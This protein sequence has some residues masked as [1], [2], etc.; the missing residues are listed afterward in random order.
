MRK[1]F[2]L[3]RSGTGAPWATK[4]LEGERRISWSGL[5]TMVFIVGPLAA[6]LCLGCSSLDAGDLAD[7]R[8][9]EVATSGSC[10][11]VGWNTVLAAVRQ[12]ERVEPR[13]EEAN[14][15]SDE[16]TC[17]DP[18]LALGDTRCTTSADCEEG[19]WRGSSVCMKVGEG[20]VPQCECRD[21]ECVAD[22][23]CPVD[24]ACFC[25]VFAYSLDPAD[26]VTEC[27]RHWDLCGSLCMPSSCRSSAEC[28]TGALCIVDL[29]PCS[30][31]VDRPERPWGAHCITPENYDCIPNSRC[32][33][34]ERPAGL[35]LACV[36][37]DDLDRW[38][39]QLE[40][41]CD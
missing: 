9:S 14:V 19:S 26:T 32:T 25:G 28:P 30:F 24:E 16:V 5:P 3:E 6:M 40:A 38:T 8:N 18:G 20:G 36:W 2:E 31:G 12:Y 34:P 17:I 23:D 15:G 11:T 33:N 1:V 37:D 22:E 4:G 13:C 27:Y 7:G 41:L 35:E 29:G 21:A 39:Y 10:G